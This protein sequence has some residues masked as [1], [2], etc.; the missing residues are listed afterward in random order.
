[1][2]ELMALLIKQDYVN[3][4]EDL[5]QDE[6]YYSFRLEY[7]KW[8]SSEEIENFISNNGKEACMIRKGEADSDIDIFGDTYE[9]DLNFY[10]D[11]IVEGQAEEEADLPTVIEAIKS[12]NPELF[13]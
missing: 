1:M 3:S 6:T 12:S 11:F 8:Y 10:V 9:V 2:P 7:V 13:I 4:I 5:N